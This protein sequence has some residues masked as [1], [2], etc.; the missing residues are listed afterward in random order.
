MDLGPGCAVL[1]RTY[2]WGDDFPITH[3][4][5]K[6]LGLHYL[7]RRFSAGGLI[8]SQ[9]HLLAVECVLKLVSGLLV[10]LGK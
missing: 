9:R 4:R 3:P 10:V 1:L 8:E 6:I 7:L 5:R 2:Q